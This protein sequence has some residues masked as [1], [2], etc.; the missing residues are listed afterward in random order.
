MRLRGTPQA[1][2]L[3]GGSAADELIGRGGNDVLRGGA[4]SDTLRGGA[5]ADLLEGGAFAD[6]LE[7]GA[8][9]DTLVFR[10]GHGGFD[11]LRGG[12]G[13]DVLLIRL[14]AAQAADAGLLAAIEA[15]R[16]DP[17]DAAAAGTLGLT[18]TGIEEIAVEIDP[19]LPRIALADIALGQGGFVIHGEAPGDWA[20]VAFATTPLGDLNGDGRADLLIGAFENDAAG[21]TAGATYVV[22]GKADGAAIELADIEDGARGYRIVGAAPGER[23]G[24]AP[25]VLGDINGDGL[26][27]LLIGAGEDG[28]GAGSVY[29]VFGRGAGPEIDLADIAG[30]VG[31]FV[32]RGEFP[33]GLVGRSVAAIGDWNGDARPDLLVGAPYAGAGQAYVVFTPADTVPTDLANVANGAGGFVLRGET[34]G[35]EAG[36]LV[37]AAG[38]I[39]GDG[40]AD[41]LV[42]APAADRAY[43]VFGGDAA[44]PDLAA[45]RRGEGGFVVLGEA[46]G[47]R[48]GF[49]VAGLGDV[50]GDGRDD[51]AVSAYDGGPDGQGRVYVVFGRAGG[52]PVDLA[53]VAGG[54]G[55]FAITGEAAG[56]R[57]GVYVAAVG[58]LNLD[59]LADLAIG[60][61]RRGAD[62]AGAVYVVFGKQGG[63]PIDL[64]SIAAGEGGFR[65]DGAEAGGLAGRAVAAAGD[66]NADG[67]PDL[68][69]GAY[70]ADG[71]GGVDSGAAY[72]VFGQESWFSP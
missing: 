49:A 37:A 3:S 62:N 19:A 22:F 31:G 43:V 10:P 38:D 7:G 57:A 48:T 50:D 67:R 52:A 18:L 5:G 21:D 39:D 60:A 4:G 17:A 45:V 25:A 26:P 63:A 14:T 42:G 15:L 61:S 47:Q 35:D 30:G 58:D 13:T 34:P 1:D 6:V 27:E 24:R 11:T 9:A 68:L 12:G 8:G 20:G 46:P 69:I 55:G 16:D 23:S 65:I 28:F 56:D 72:V 41:L 54:Q 70:Q 64:A 53:A 2:T 36:L 59:G 40:R 51:F 29:V 32:I 44:P 33:L 66:V 71:P